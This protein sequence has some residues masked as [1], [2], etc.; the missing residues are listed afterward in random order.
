MAVVYLGG[1]GQGKLVALQTIKAVSP[2]KRKRGDSEE[3]GLRPVHTY[4]L[5]SDP[6]CMEMQRHRDGE[7]L[8]V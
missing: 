3:W 7:A 4:Q 6:S 5:D 2:A 8:S 1:R